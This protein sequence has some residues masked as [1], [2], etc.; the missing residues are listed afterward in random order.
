MWISVLCLIY[1]KNYE[2]VVMI[3]DFVFFLVF[4]FKIFLENCL[5]FYIFKMVVKNNDDI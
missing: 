4:E 3:Y 5:D 1:F 2:W